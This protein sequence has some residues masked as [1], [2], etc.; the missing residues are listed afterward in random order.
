[1]TA[2]KRPYDRTSHIM[3]VD[4]DQTLLKFFKIH[5]N[6][7]FSRVIVVKSAKEAQDTLK[8]KEIDLVLSDIRMPRVSGLS[9]LKKIRNYDASIPV[10]LISG[11]LLTE[12]QMVEIHE[13]AD[14]FLRKPFTVDQIQDF[15]NE[16]MERRDLLKEL[17]DIVEDKKVLKDLVTGKI[18]TRRFSKEPEVKAKVED[19]LAKLS[20]DQP[21]E[22][23]EAS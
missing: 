16:G 21:K 10:Y 8:E 5:L 3:V 6:K 22:T 2:P 9:L 14:G 18:T 20:E 1:M 7:F 12:E 13:V 15:I 11:A 17:S 4:D 23:S 19:L